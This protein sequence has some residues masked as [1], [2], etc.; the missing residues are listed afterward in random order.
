[1]REMEPVPTFPDSIDALLRAALEDPGA[2]AA[3]LARGD[4][5]LDGPG[6]GGLLA[7]AAVEVEG[8]DRAVHELLIQIALAAP[9]HPTP[10]LLLLGAA[11]GFDSMAALA[12]EVGGAPET[13]EL[14][15]RDA[16]RARL[17]ADLVEIDAILAGPRPEDARARARAIAEEAEALGDPD[18]A[19]VMA[20]VP[21]RLA[22]IAESDR[23][24]KIRA[25]ALASGI[26]LLAGAIAVLSPS[27]RS[28][29]APERA[30][31]PAA[32]AGPV[33]GDGARWCLQEETILRAAA[34][35][36]NRVSGGPPP[37]AARSYE[38]AVRAW[39]ASCGSGYFGTSR[40]DAEAW[41]RQPGRDLP[42]QVRERLRLW[43]VQAP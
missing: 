16:R 31:Q 25:L 15:R 21:E 35:A 18:L 43:G 14:L 10:R 26:A 39:S 40:A 13:I 37:A 32:G 42:G 29:P 33:A 27:L 2:T 23:G 3:M 17:R 6:L 19:A 9:E 41:L 28:P 7:R 24:L 20:E 12:Q 30:V 4:L 38:E 36:L 34:E 5:R 22:R 1:M 11:A 8:G